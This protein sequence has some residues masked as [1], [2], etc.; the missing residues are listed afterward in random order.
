VSVLLD[1]HVLLWWRAGGDRLS[2]DARAQ[3]RAANPVLISP[4][5][6]WE[7]GTLLRQ[8]RIALDRPLADWVVDLL[9]DAQIDVAA[10]SPRAAAEAGSLPEAFPGDPADRL[11]Y[12]T[13]AE[14]RVALISKD[15]RLRAYADSHA[16][17][18]LW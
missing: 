10:L 7:V 18:V 6:F 11:I 3:I 8:G 15:E 9:A 14:L 16:I 17:H 5:T 2:P 13:A 12:A 1:T 4:I